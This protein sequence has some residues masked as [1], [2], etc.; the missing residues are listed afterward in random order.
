M[1]GARNPPELQGI[2]PRAIE[3]IFDKISS[4]QGGVNGE[5]VRTLLIVALFTRS[6]NDAV[7]CFV[8]FLSDRRFHRDLQ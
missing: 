1:E 7:Y 3:H 4:D 5:K 8:D 2:V 6:V